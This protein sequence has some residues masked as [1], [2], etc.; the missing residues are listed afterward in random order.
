MNGRMEKDRNIIVGIDFGTTYTAAAWT[1]S[2]SPSHVEVI[3]NWPTAGPVV[4]SQVPTE[5][6]YGRDDRDRYSWGYNIKP[7]AEKVIRR[8]S[9]AVYLLVNLVSRSSGSSSASK[10]SRIN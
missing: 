9:D 10:L 6:A 5:I 8:L 3:K 2:L 7:Q 4:S 1:D